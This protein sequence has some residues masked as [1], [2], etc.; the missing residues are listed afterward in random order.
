MKMTAALTHLPFQSRKV[1][2]YKQ[3]LKWDIVFL[4]MSFLWAIP[5]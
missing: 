5:G 2:I 4:T 1:K 3:I